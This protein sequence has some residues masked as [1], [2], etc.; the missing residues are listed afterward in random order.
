MVETRIAVKELEPGDILRQRYT[1][2][3]R[4]RETEGHRTVVIGRTGLEGLAY[5][6]RVHAVI[7][8]AGLDPERK[9]EIEWL[10]VPDQPVTVIRS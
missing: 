9:A 1:V 5:R 6:G 7:R 10:A 4:G 8:V 2:K 3:E